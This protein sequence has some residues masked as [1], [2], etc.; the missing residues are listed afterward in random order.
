MS[1][2]EVQPKIGNLPPTE[3]AAEGGIDGKA[4]REAGALA[5][6][7]YEEELRE[8]AMRDDHNRSRKF[9]D[10]FES[11]SIWGLRVGAVGLL[12]IAISWLIHLVVPQLGWLTEDQVGVLQ[13]LLTG[14][15]LV[16]AFAEHFRK[17][18]GQ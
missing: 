2:P 12:A 18:I 3:V 6:G 15:I 4:D 5:R 7:T 17:R 14:G 13:N 11:I 8:L 9:K 1:E 10:T 16:S